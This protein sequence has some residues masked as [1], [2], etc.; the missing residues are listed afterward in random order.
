MTKLKFLPGVPAT[1]VLDRLAKAGGNEVES[2]KLASPESSAALAVN[3]F[4]WFYPCPKLLPPFP[5]LD[6]GFPPILVDVEYQARFPWPGGKHPWL[7]AV[8]ITTSHLIGVESKRFEPFRDKK[9]VSLAAAHDGPVWGDAMK[10]YELLRDKLRS[11]EMRFEYLDSAQLVKHAFG[12]V[13]DAKRK[14]KKPALVYLFA[15]PASL[16]GRP[17]PEISIQH[18]RAEVA[19]FADAVRGAEVGFHAS[20]Y[21]EWIASWAQLD[22]SVVQH[23]EALLS[24]FVP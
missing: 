11:G 14:G 20:S 2:G 10:P 13:T 16:N 15:E 12:L 5:G 7:D 8:L 17:I 24:E 3:C 23:G 4:G 1:H 9:S 22:Q 6:A 21:R 18:H 19:A